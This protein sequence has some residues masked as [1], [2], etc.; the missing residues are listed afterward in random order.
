MYFIRIIFIIYLFYLPVS[1]QVMTPHYIL[2]GVHDSV[3]K[4]SVPKSRASLV[5]DC[6]FNKSRFDVGLLDSIRN[7]NIDTILLVYTAFRQAES[8]NQSDL[9]V[10]RL[11]ELKQNMPYIFENNLIHWKVVRQTGAKDDQDAKAYFHGFVIKFRNTGFV[12][13]LTTEK[14]IL[15]IKDYLR[16]LRGILPSDTISGDDIKDIARP[17]IAPAFTITDTLI[18]YPFS[19]RK[20]RYIDINLLK[21]DYRKAKRYAKLMVEL[22]PEEKE[23]LTK[24]ILDTNDV[25]IKY[26]P[27]FY[28][29]KSKRK[30]EKGIL[31][32]RRTILKRKLAKDTLYIRTRA[33]HT[34]ISGGGYPVYLY[35][36]HLTLT[37]E[38]F[39]NYP[40]PD[41][42]VTVSL[43]M[44]NNH[45]DNVLVEDVTGSMYPYILQTFL[46]RRLYISKAGLRN[47]VFFNDGDRTPDHLKRIGDTKGIYSIST[48]SILDV[49]ELVY[50]TMSK[51][52]GGDGPENNIEALI[53]AQE[54]FPD[55]NLVMIADNNALVKDISLLD[56]ITRPVH[57]ILCGT[58]RGVMANYITIAGKTGGRLTTIEK[59]YY[60]LKDLK[61]GDKITIG[62]QTF[63]MTKTGLQLTR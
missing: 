9:N 33:F 28:I 63:I 26:K 45:A 4:F 30:K 13:P 10:L 58:H 8:F 14:E 47:F 29:P 1:A 11:N 54:K 59:T 52:D 57:V 55:K 37:P 42:V 41:S 44:E 62:G 46:W 51:G 35:R 61:E 49:E 5:L 43:K 7:K 15:F 40:F 23:L 16:S 2:G 36:G 50:A 6:G 12:A 3:R 39:V 60:G 22:K 32:T 31:Y 18:K 27:L 21:S 56:K 19:G 38:R 20:T 24:I 34:G 17:V 25:K 53:Y 48:D